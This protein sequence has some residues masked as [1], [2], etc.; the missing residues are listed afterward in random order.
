MPQLDIP[1]SYLQKWLPSHTLS[2]SHFLSH[3]ITQAMEEKH[4]FFVNDA[5]ISEYPSNASAEDLDSILST[6]APSPSLVRDLISLIQSTSA[7]TAKSL[8][9]THIKSAKPKHFPLWVITYWLE[10]DHIKATQQSWQLAHKSLQR[11]Y[12]GGGTEMK[13]LVDQVYQAL[14]SLR[15]SGSVQ[16]FNEKVSDWGRS[17]REKLNWR[18]GIQIVCGLKLGLVL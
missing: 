14:S 13:K 8:T 5:Y 12:Q 6:P 7:P 16:A 4:E 11:L 15:W 1:L 9:C 18:P 17:W 10:I 3:K 2:I